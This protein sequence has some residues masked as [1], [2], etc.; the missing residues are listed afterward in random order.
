MMSSRSRVRSLPQMGAVVGLA[1]AMLSAAGCSM[2]ISL[3]YSPLAA[4]EAIATGPTRPRAFVTRFSDERKGE[5]VGEI[6]NTLGGTAKKLV[7]TDDVGSLF[8]EAATDALNKAGLVAHLHSERTAEGDIP[9]AELAGYDL[10][11]GGRIKEF[12]VVSQPGWDTLKVTSRAVIE[13][14]VRKGGKTEWIGP[15]EGT[16]ERREVSYIQS[17]GLTNG[18]DSALQNCMRNMIKHL[19]ASGVLESPPAN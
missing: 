6:K 17:Q 1:F 19:K 12:E 2:P 18:L 11:V 14:G 15:I 10:V 3:K 9:A 13:L 7:T 8:A 5:T 4:T 16:A